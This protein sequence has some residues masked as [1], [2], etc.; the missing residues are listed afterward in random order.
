MFSSLQYHRGCLT[1]AP[2]S[3]LQAFRF[4]IYFILT[5]VHI[6][7]VTLVLWFY[8][9]LGPSS[10]AGMGAVLMQ[11]PMLYL[12]GQLYAKLRWGCR[13]NVVRLLLVVL[14]SSSTVHNVILLIVQSHGNC[15]M[16]R[17]FDHK[18]VC[19]GWVSLYANAYHYSQ[20][21]AAVCCT[22][23]QVTFQHWC[24]PLH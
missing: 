21:P 22:A 10:L 23:P 15:Y 16:G 8:I 6:I 1:S 3:F 18:G 5:P 13:I 11:I 7:A 9:G 14:T 24:M 17:I 12:F 20:L 4:S 2:Y 19:I